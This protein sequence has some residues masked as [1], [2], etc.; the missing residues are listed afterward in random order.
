MTII[1]RCARET[2][3]NFMAISSNEDANV[4]WDDP[5]EDNGMALSTVGPYLTTCFYNLS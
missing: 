1:N 5:T 2:G 3:S 4:L